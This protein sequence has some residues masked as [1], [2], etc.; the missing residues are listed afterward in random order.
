MNIDRSVISPLT[1][2]LIVHQARPLYTA[3]DKHEPALALKRQQQKS[4]LSSAVLLRLNELIISAL[5]LLVQLVCL[6]TEVHDL[7][8]HFDVFQVCALK[9]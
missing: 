3:T 5:L 7:D 1:V 4:C 6:S 9:Q 2:F 8:D